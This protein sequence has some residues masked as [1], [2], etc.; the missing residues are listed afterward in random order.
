MA[1][2]ETMSFQKE[3]KKLSVYPEEG[4][5]LLYGILEDR[6]DTSEKAGLGPLE[7]TGVSV[8]QHRKSLSVGVFP[9]SL[10]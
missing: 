4:G 10:W 7:R 3:I 8:G 2:L 9:V 5:D 1:G 6:T